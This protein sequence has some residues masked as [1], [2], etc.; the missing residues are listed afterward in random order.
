LGSRSAS[1][2]HSCLRG[3]RES[4]L[5]GVCELIFGC[6]I[7][8]FGPVRC[9]TPSDF[10]TAAPALLWVGVSFSDRLVFRQTGEVSEQ[11]FDFN[12]YGATPSAFC[13][14]DLRAYRR[15]EVIFRLWTHKFVESG[16]VQA[17]D[18]FHGT[19]RG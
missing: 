13:S 12:Q 7:K 14:Q 16:S 9:E 17:G 2:L 8:G 1:L 6:G 19:G 11:R 3:C 4:L 15:I 18:G 10:V 5:Y